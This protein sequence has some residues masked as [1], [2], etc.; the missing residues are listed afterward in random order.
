MR[1]LVQFGADPNA[2]SQYSPDALMGAAATGDIALAE[3][4]IAHG[5]DTDD[6][7]SF[8]QEAALASAA[9]AGHVAA[10]RWLLDRFGLG[11]D[12]GAAALMAAAHHN[13]LDV[14]RLLLDGGVDADAYAHDRFSTDPTS[15]YYG[16]TALV[17]AAWKG[18]AAMARLLLERGA[19]VNTAL[20]RPSAAVFA[21]CAGR[22]QIIPLLIEWGLEP[23]HKDAALLAAISGRHSSTAELLLQGGADPNAVGYAQKTALMYAAEYGTPALIQSLLNYGATVDAVDKEGKTAQMWAEYAGQSE[24]SALF[25]RLQY[26]K[27]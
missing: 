17:Y 20:A 1:L 12:K 24:I 3:F 14:V 21:A 19:D 22:K 25:V 26:D 4:L 2:R 8:R 18:G 15:T 9:G 6:A 13:H 11:A 5:A 7:A 16:R 27:I 23:K 10:T